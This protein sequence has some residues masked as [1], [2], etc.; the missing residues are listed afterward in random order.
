MSCVL[1]QQSSFTSPF[2]L[3]APTATRSLQLQSSVDVAVSREPSLDTP[4]EPVGLFQASYAVAGQG[5]KL[6]RGTVLAHTADDAPAGAGGMP[7]GMCQV[8]A[9]ELLASVAM[10]TVTAASHP[11]R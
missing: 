1:V 3:S 6:Q 11:G 8:Y 5:G 7:E 9:A 10:T 2:V 4:A